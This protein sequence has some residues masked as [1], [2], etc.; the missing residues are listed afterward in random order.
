MED[1]LVK[2]VREYCTYTGKSREELGAFMYI[3][4]QTKN[5]ELPEKKLEMGAFARFLNLLAIGQTRR[6]RAQGHDDLADML[7][8]EKRLSE[9]P[10]YRHEMYQRYIK[11]VKPFLP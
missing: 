7:I 1:D 3:A 10:K 8:Q 9:K 11:E 4:G 6:Y 5:G 2:K